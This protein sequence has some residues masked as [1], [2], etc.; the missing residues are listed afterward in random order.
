[1]EVNETW[2]VART[3]CSLPSLCFS[4]RSK[5]K[6]LPD[7]PLSGWDIFDFSSETAE[8]NSTKLDMNK[9]STFST[10]FVGFFG[11]LIKTRWPPWP[12]LGWDIF[13][14]SYEIADRSS[15]I[16]CRKKDIHVLYQVCVF[17]GRSEKQDGCPSYWLADT[18]LTSHLESLNG[19]Q[20]N[21]TGKQD[22]SVI[23]QFCVF[24]VDRKTK[25]P[26]RPLIGWDIFDFSSATSEWNWTKLDRTQDL[27]V[28]RCTLCAM[29]YPS[30]QPKY[31]SW[32]KIKYALS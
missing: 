6:R 22:L 3:Q 14:F 31:I 12:L 20:L 18:F 28:I 32:K 27:K 21:L 26:L 30:L 4:D 16:L 7:L 5:K 1:M 9:I 10:K 2:N 29:L 15:T 13:N 25:W 11:R 8:W 17:S 24:R 23:Y 19:S